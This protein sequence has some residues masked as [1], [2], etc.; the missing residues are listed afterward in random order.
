MTRP[1]W[2]LRVT[3]SAITVLAGTTL[4]GSSCAADIRDGIRSAG[5]DFVEGTAGSILDRF[6]PIDD[7][8]NPPDPA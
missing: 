2:L 8:L 7:F 4:F 5:L 3:T 6:I 1:S